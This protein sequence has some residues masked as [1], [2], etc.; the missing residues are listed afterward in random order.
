MRRL[1]E[2]PSGSDVAR[3]AR[4]RDAA[5]R[6]RGNPGLR[7][8]L[9]LICLLVGCGVS[10]PRADLEAYG[11]ERG[12]LIATD[13]T[14]PQPRGRYVAERVMLRSSTGLTVTGQLLRPARGGCFPAVLLHD[15]REEN[16]DVIGRLPADFGDV[17]VLSLDYP[18]EVPYAV[19]LRDFVFHRDRLRDGARQIPADFSLGAAYLSERDEVDTSRIAIAA[20]SFAVPFA[21]I[22]AALDERF[23][24]IA[25]VYGAGQLS[26]VL[27]A[28]L[29]GVPRAL[30]APVAAVV[31]RSFAD[32]APE[33]FIGLVA[34]RPIVMVNG[35]DDPQMPVPAAEHLYDA[36]REPKTMIW[37]RTGHL[38]PTDSALIRSL[39]DTAFARLPVLRHADT[40][41][42][43]S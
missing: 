32:F 21:V 30:R 24:N 2:G 42:R 18:D 13:T 28:N 37:L 35:I 34:P 4:P 22:A 41:C 26:S 40:K 19:R 3:E 31:M 16:S 12:T 39:I 14:S 17:V 29:T 33:R 7:V 27:A 1:R 9:R 36:A 23:R 8:L 5:R 25:L 10:S 6:T 11:R 20:T 15:G 43:G 38:M